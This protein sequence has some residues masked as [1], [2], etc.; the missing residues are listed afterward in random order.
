MSGSSEG[1]SNFSLDAM[2]GRQ[3]VSLPRFCPVRAIL[4]SSSWSDY[5][6]PNIC[7]QVQVWSGYR[8]KLTERDLITRNQYPNR[9][10]IHTISNVLTSNVQPSQKSRNYDSNI[11]TSYLYPWLWNEMLDKMVS[12]FFRMLCW[13]GCS[14]EDDIFQPFNDDPQ[15]LILIWKLYFRSITWQ[16]Q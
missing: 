9:I 6:A 16:S 15:I 4:F 5:E 7:E 12:T 8:H 2:K 3:Q 1:I 14:Y 10:A 11:P 13:Y